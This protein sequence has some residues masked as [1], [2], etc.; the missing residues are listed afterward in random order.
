MK[1]NKQITLKR[2]ETCIK[3]S[4]TYSI[5]FSRCTLVLNYETSW[6][7]FVSIV[8]IKLPTGLIIVYIIDIGCGILYLGCY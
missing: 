6:H 3:W 4:L 5:M 8:N 1:E 2:E 7:V